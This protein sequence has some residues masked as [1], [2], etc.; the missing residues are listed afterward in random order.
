MAA[1]GRAAA[2]PARQLR[3]SGAPAF[4]N[5]NAG[6]GRRLEPIQEVHHH[7]HYNNGNRR[8]F[9]FNLFVGGGNWGFGVGVN[10]GFG[11]P[12][13]GGG[14]AFHFGFGGGPWYDASYLYGPA[15]AGY[16]NNAYWGWGR[17]IPFAYRGFYRHS[18]FHFGYNYF[19]PFAAYT[20]YPFYRTTFF[21]PWYVRNFVVGC[22][23]YRTYHF[24]NY[25]VPTYVEST[26]PYYEED[27]VVAAG[28][29]DWVDDGVVPISAAPRPADA[30][31]EFRN[32]FA[33]IP[34]DLSYDE[35]LAWGEEALYD[36][37]LARAAEAFRRAML[38][39]G[40]AYFPK[41]QLALAL[42]GSDNYRLAGL[43]LELG[44]DQ[45]PAWVFRRF[46]LSDAFR[47]PELL[48]AAVQRLE[49][50]LIV[51]EADDR[52]RFVLGYAYYFTGNLFGARGVFKVLSER[53][54]PLPHVDRL[55]ASAERRLIGEDR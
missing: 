12:F 8:S 24:V 27:V 43:A 51:N 2:A 6:V 26:D 53:I 10:R 7:H 28:L 18:R 13:Y 47:D 16:W 4:R 19:Y 44:F 11:H 5:R 3:A 9:G 52:A 1:G 22:P 49:R 55:A 54:A 29:E 23:T 20:P 45:N 14:S 30:F 42:F 32:P 25:D 21:E 15:Y 33:E 41:F 40:E 35:Y 34:A 46:N 17:R 31:A 38:I 39:R 48:A 37:D 50:H 36:G